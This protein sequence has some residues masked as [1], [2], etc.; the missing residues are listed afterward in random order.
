MRLTKRE[1]KLAELP[2]DF[3]EMKESEEQRI[4][5][6][7]G[8]E[9]I[10]RRNN[11]SEVLVDTIDGAFLHAFEAEDGD[12]DD[13][14]TGDQDPG[15]SDGYFAGWRDQ[16][17]NDHLDGDPITGE[18][19]FQFPTAAELR[20]MVSDTWSEQ[21]DN[22]PGPRE[23]VWHGPESITIGEG[24]TVFVIQSHDYNG[25]GVMEA[26][27]TNGRG[28]VRTFLSNRIM[29]RVTPTCP[30]CG[31]PLDEDETR[32]MAQFLVR[33]AWTARKRQGHKVR[34]FVCT[35]CHYAP[36]GGNRSGGLFTSAEREK[37]RILPPPP[38]GWDYALKA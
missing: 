35:D 8:S 11:T 27:T 16:G 22:L 7:Q 20:G 32:N 10:G 12:R 9:H 26:A 21:G 18:D 33:E 3:I 17:R 24:I 2:V 37:L 13:E 19:P 15:M 5:G 23:R 36:R 29:V 38:L 6:R 30:K 28:E 14:W 4:G 31:Q 34:T 25:D 1:M